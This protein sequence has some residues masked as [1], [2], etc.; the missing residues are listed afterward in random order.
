MIE[1][2]VTVDGKT[3]P[4]YCFESSWEKFIDWLEKIN[5]EAV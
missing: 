5:V 1:C 2:Q 3:Y 4:I